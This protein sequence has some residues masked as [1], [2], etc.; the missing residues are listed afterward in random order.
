MLIQL[1]QSCVIAA[2]IGGVFF[3]IGTTQVSVAKRLPL[4]F[5][6][7]INQGIF[8][9]L[10]VI[11]SF[12]AERVL[13]LRER[14]A[15]MYR[16]SAYF[17][18]KTTAGEARA[19]CPARLPGRLPV[20]LPAGGGGS[21]GRQRMRASARAELDLCPSLSPS[22]PFSTL[23]E[24]AMYVLSPVCFSSI[25]Y[26]MTGLQ[27]GGMAPCAAAAP[28]ICL[29]AALPPC[30]TSRSL[31]PTNAVPS[32][33]PSLHP[34]PPLQP[35]FGRFVV[36]T[37]FMVLCQQAA[38]S[39]AQAVSALCRDVDTSGEEAAQLRCYV[40]HA[41][42]ALAMPL[43]HCLLDLTRP[44]SCLP[45]PASAPRRSHR[46]AHGA[47]DHAALR[48]LLPGARAA[49]ALD[50]GTGLHQVCAGWVGGAQRGGT[51]VGVQLRGAAG[52][53]TLATTCPA[54]AHPCPACPQ[55]HP[56]TPPP[57]AATCAT[58]TL[59]WPSTSCRAW[60]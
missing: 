59:G 43:P 26:W 9:A 37:C 39:L 29:L 45:P 35:D 34:L 11:N 55:P 48:R 54:T 31:L 4:L 27:V 19:G 41:F 24:S 30:R 6:C 36:F 40:M 14:A 10:G 60:C 38:V 7:T 2:L 28:A 17:L 25:A 47:R 32:S 58:P 53:R 16:A 18:A 15:G 3:Q 22:A 23:A 5:F 33:P 52:P 1:L 8:G 12:P 57:A 50:G 20:R 13:T 21:P 42:A 56:P 49:A 46:A 44:R 51:A